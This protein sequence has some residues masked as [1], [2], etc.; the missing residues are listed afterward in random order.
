MEVEASLSA[1][2]ARELTPSVLSVLR[3][4]L[5]AVQRTLASSD[6]KV[7]DAAARAPMPGHENR[8]ASGGGA[9]AVPVPPPAA[10]ATAIR[11]SPRG[12]S[13]CL[14][15]PQS[16]GAPSGGAVGGA[17][18]SDARDTAAAHGGRVLSAGGQLAYFS[19]TPSPYAGLAELPRSY[20]EFERGAGVAAAA[21]DRAPSERQWATPASAALFAAALGAAARRGGRAVAPAAAD[22]GVGGRWARRRGSWTSASAG[23]RGVAPS[24]G[25]GGSLGGGVTLLNSLGDATRARLA[26]CDASQEWAEISYD[27]ACRYVLPD[28]GAA[29][30][31]DDD[32]DGDGGEGDG[33]GARGGG[34]VRDERGGGGGRGQRRASAV[35]LLAAHA[36][37]AHQIGAR[38]PKPT[39]ATF[40]VGALLAN[41]F[42]D[43]LERDAQTI[44]LLSATAA[45]VLDAAPP[46]DGGAA[47]AAAAALPSAA[48][49]ARCC[50]VYAAALLRWGRFHVGS[51]CQRGGRRLDADTLA[52]LEA[53]GGRGYA[54][55]DAPRA[56]ELGEIVADDGADDVAA[57]RAPPTA[58]GASASASPAAAAPAAA[59]AGGAAA[60]PAGGNPAPSQPGQRFASMPSGMNAAR[61]CRR[62]G[63]R[64]ATWPPA[65]AAAAR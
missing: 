2:A 15:Q 60:P 8:E 58:A 53:T 14:Q 35:W 51:S 21:D 3:A 47:P 39:F 5:G 27:L 33:G 40:D 50:E 22:D 24:L 37:R 1:L 43:R 59:A 54:L 56:E 55:V 20:A 65:A 45:T 48:V 29:A 61:T 25:V 13:R 4:V 10:A 63:S 46:A 16:D 9:P 38:G 44:A 52:T 7:E 49:R 19:N 6:R 42:A 41:L 30:S 31:D 36:L 57:D 11:C 17:A 23:R 32:G 28:L 62:R 64:A 12:A 34:G 26:I 18:D